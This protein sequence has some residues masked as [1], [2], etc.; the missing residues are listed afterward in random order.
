MRSEPERNLSNALGTKPARR[1]SIWLVA[2]A[3]CKCTWDEMVT[4]R[5]FS[6]FGMYNLTG[7]AA[8]SEQVTDQLRA[9]GGTFPGLRGVCREHLAACALHPRA[10]Q[11]PP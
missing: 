11:L 4:K 10:V 8:D 7:A 5:S 6:V 3:S 1:A 2:K 9:L